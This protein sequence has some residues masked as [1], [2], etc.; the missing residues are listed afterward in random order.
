VGGDL[1]A[2][3]QLSEDITDALADRSRGLC[4][5]PG[6][7]SYSQTGPLV[8]EGSPDAVHRLVTDAVVRGGRVLCS[9]FA[10]DGPGWFYP[11]TVVTDVHTSSAILREE[12]FGLV[13]PIVSVRTEDEAVCVANNYEAGATG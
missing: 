7:R 9:G 12:I 1:L 5:G 10:P 4:P 6:L 8:D 13:A 11:P 2:L 3:S